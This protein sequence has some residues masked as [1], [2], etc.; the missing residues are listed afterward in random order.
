VGRVVPFF[1]ERPLITAKQLDFERFAAVLRMMRAGDHLSDAGLRSIARITEQMNRKRRSR[2]L[3]SSEAI[4]Q[5]SHV[6]G[7]MKRWSEPHGDMRGDSSEIPCRVSSDL[8]EWRN[9]LA[10]VS[11][12]DP[13]KLKSE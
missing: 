1:E 10:T 8:H 2:F 11:T 9:D 6:D 13:A 4:R 12:T 7:E 5:P 3:E